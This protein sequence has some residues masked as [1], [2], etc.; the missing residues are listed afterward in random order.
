MNTEIPDD[1]LGDA[2]YQEPWQ[3]I[4]EDYLPRFAGGVPWVD[5]FIR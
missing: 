2:D 1:F 4:F 5:S 3:R